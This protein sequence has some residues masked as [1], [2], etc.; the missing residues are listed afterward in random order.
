MKCCGQYFKLV[1]K[2]QNLANLTIQYNF[3]VHVKKGSNQFV[4]G[5]EKKKLSEDNVRHFKTQSKIIALDGQQ[6]IIGYMT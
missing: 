6:V 2:Q 5:R 3:K 4:L 1:I